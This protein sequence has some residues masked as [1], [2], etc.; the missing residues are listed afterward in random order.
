MN[1]DRAYEIARKVASNQGLD[2][3]Q[4]EVHDK[5]IENLYWVIFEVKEYHKAAGWK[6]HF[7]IRVSRD[8]LAELY[9]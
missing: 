6:N 4:Y 9:R 3:K 8:G 2:P 1:K 5:E 7:A